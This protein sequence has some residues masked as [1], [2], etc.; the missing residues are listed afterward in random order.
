[1]WW[2]FSKK[3]GA[4]EPAP[5]PSPSGLR[6]AA[7]VV[8]I[9]VLLSGLVALLMRATPLQGL[10][11]CCLP[12]LGYGSAIWLPRKWH[13]PHLPFT[14]FVVSGLPAFAVFLASAVG[15]FTQML[16][17]R[18]VGVLSVAVTLG[19]VAGR[20]HLLSR[21]KEPSRLRAVVVGTQRYCSSLDAEL[22]RLV[23][24]PV[25]LIGNIELGGPDPVPL[26]SLLREQRVDLLLT[27]PTGPE[28]ALFDE[29]EKNAFEVPVTVL[30]LSTFYELMLGRAPLAALEAPWLCDL[31]KPSHRGSAAI[32][33]TV[34]LI[35]S[36]TAMALLAPVLLVLAYLVRRDGGPAS[37]RQPR[38][39]KGGKSFEILKLRTMRLDEDVSSREVVWS[40]QDD[41]RVTNVGRFLRASHLDEAPQLINIIRGEMSLV[42]PRPEQADVVARLRA[43]IPFYDWRHRVRPGLTGW[44]QVIAGYCGTEQGSVVKTCY[45]LYYLKY[46]SLGLDVCIL[47]ETVRTTIA[48]RQW[49]TLDFDATYIPPAPFASVGFDDPAIQGPGIDLRTNED[50]A[51]HEIVEHADSAPTGEVIR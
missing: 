1:M 11:A 20:T 28:G 13:L 51:W 18:T 8:A 36:V 34:D 39:G 43:E 9:G 49:R 23:H 16:S 32:R 47:C 14:A 31:L 41:D 5:P 15:W 17:A 6:V 50:A 12:I 40:R 38:V 48:D 24:C 22:S 19:F 33:R 37:F 4:P 42:G 3:S 7:Q 21:P 25:E 29:I 44:A 2:Q 35:V 30:Q 10:F 45:D 27:A 46:R 26:A